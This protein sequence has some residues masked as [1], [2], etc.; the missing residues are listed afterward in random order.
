[1]KFIIT[2]SQLK[3]L[4]ESKYFN[5]KPA[6][7]FD[8]YYKSDIGQTYDFP[9]G[10]SSDEVW[11]IIQDCWEKRICNPLFDLLENLSEEH[12]PYPGIEKFH[13]EVKA[14]ILMGMAS[15]LN[16]DDVV[17]YAIK[18][19]NGLHDKGFNKFHAKQKPSVQNRL[20]W[21]ILG[22]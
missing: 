15:E 14:E 12:F 7:E 21:I 8:S 2:E 17:H 6:R 9:G 3:K 20:Q 1:M 11:D 13:D 22:M 18:G 4:I 16:F 10:L 5:Y 19:Q